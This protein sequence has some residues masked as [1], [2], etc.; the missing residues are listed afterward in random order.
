MTLSITL[1]SFAG[2]PPMIGFFAKQIVFSAALDKSDIFVVL[3]AI[4]TS[5]SS[6]SCHLNI[7]K[8]MFFFRHEYK[9]IFI[10]C[11]LVCLTF[12]V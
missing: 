2:V 8:E 7:V 4:L 10:I 5:V 3:I 12:K 11:T 9:N 1:L 6:A